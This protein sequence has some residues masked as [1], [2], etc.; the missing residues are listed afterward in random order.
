MSEAPFRIRD[1]RNG[2]LEGRHITEKVFFGEKRMKILGEDAEKT[3]ET[4]AA[5]TVSLETARNDAICLR[6]LLCFKKKIQIN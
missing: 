3:K 5:R 1:W 6:V 4:S 2:W